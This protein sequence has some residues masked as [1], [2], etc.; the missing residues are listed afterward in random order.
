MSNK[1]QEIPGFER[2]L[3]RLLEFLTSSSDSFA[4]PID[5]PAE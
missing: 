1:I 3:L 4:T 5:D 2:T